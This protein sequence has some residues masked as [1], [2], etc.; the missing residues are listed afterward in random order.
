MSSKN[1]SYKEHKS[2]VPLADL[3]NHTNERLLLATACHKQVLGGSPDLPL[4]IETDYKAGWDSASGQSVYKQKFETEEG[5]EKFVPESLLSTCIVPLRFRCQ[6]QVLWENPVPQGANFCRPLRLAFEKESD[7]NAMAIKMDLDNQVKS[8][9]EHET[10]VDGH[11]V[12]FKSCVHTTMLDGKAKNAASG[13][14]STLS[15]FICKAK[16]NDFNNLEN[17]TSGK[18]VENLAFLLFG[19]SPMHLWIKILELILYIGS[20]KETERWRKSKALGDE[21]TIKARKTAIQQELKARLGLLVDMP[22]QGG[23]GNSNDGNTARRLFQNSAVFAE[24][25]GVSKELIDHLHIL[26]CTINCDHQIDADKFASYC[27]ETA[28]LYVS[29]YNWY[30]MP[31]SLHVLLFHGPSYLKMID[32]LF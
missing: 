28:Q 20:K 21:E 14:K 18:F 22:R 24:V 10:E 31:V 5:E 29:L 12:T 11:L 1:I 27:L 6:G 23:S 26:L 17:F 2:S 30:K 13:H 3:L 19:L 4:V 25:T 32:W 8:L 7:E 16:P 15:C 9:T